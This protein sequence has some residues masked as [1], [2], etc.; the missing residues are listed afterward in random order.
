VQFEACRLEERR[1]ASVIL[2]EIRAKTKDIP[3]VVI[4]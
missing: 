4:G 2:D 1:K 3:G